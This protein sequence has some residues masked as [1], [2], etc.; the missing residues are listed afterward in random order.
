[1]FANLSSMIRRSSTAEISFGSRPKATFAFPLVFGCLLVFT[2]APGASIAEAAKKLSPLPLDLARP[3]GEDSFDRPP[4]VKA[5]QS[6][7]APGDTVTFGYV[8]ANG[9]AVEGEVWTFD[10]GHSDPFEGWYATD[11]T[12]NTE[13]YFRR[14][15][16]AEWIAD[17]NNMVAPPVLS[18]TGSAW[19]GAFGTEAN[20]LCW[21]SGLGYGN[22]WCQRL[23]SPTF[24][25][26]GSSSVSASWLHF[27]DTEAMYD[28]TTVYLK[29]L[30][31]GD[32]LELARYD[33][34][35][36][37]APD[38]PDSPPVGAGDNVTLDPADF[39]GETSYQIVFE[40]T[41][42]HGWS[43]SDGFA[44]TEYGP[45]AFDNVDIDG[46]VFDFEADLQGWVPEVC[47]G[48][49]SQFGVA[50]VGD[51]LIEDACGC[52]LSGNVLEF[53]DESREHPYGQR[54]EARS[55][56][57]DLLN[58]TEPAG[59]GNLSIL[60]RWAQY[61]ELPQANGVFYRPG[62]DFYPFECV[63]T[64]AEG[65]SGRV[66]QNSFFFV[67]E[68]P[69]C[70]QNVTVATEVDRPVP[71]T[72]EQVRFIFEI[73]ASCDA[74][75]IPGDVCTNQTNFTP[76]IDN[77]VIETTKVPDAPAIS[78][79]NGLRYQDGYSQDPV[80]YWFGPGNADVT[81]NRNF[82]NTTPVVLGDSLYVS[83]PLA[84]PDPESQWEAKLWFQIPRVGPLLN[85][86]YMEWRDRVRDG[87]NIDP[88]LGGD[89]IEWTFAFMDSY[90][91]GTNVA[92]NKYVSYFREDDDDF[93]PGEELKDAN[94]IIADGVLS[95][96]TQVNYFVSS[97]FIG[98]SQQF[99][100]P[101]TTGGFSLEFE[102]LPRWRETENGLKFP[103]TLY[104]DAANDGAQFFVESALDKLGIEVDRYD[105]LD[106]TSN[107]K[108]PFRRG[109][110]A[111]SNN[112][113]TILQLRDY[114]T[115]IVNSGEARTTSIMWPDD[116]LHFADW[117][118]AICSF[119]NRGFIANGSGLASS[120]KTQAPAFLWQLGGDLVSDSYSEYSGDQSDCVRLETEAGSTPA[121]GTSNSLGDYEYDA[122]GNWCPTNHR[123]DVLGLAPGQGGVGN[124]VYLDVDDLETEVPYAQ[125]AN[126][127]EY[128]DGFVTRTVLDGTSYHLLSD[129][130]PLLE[131]VSDS[132]HIV[133]AAANELLAAMEWIWGVGQIPILTDDSPC[134]VSDAPN[135]HGHL[136][137]DVTAMYSSFPN[138]YNRRTTLRFALA[139]S[140]EA[141]VAIYDAAGRL[142]R[143]VVDGLHDA[144]LHQ[145]IWDGTDD[146]G[147][148]LPSGVYW[149]R[150]WDGIQESSAKL[151]SLR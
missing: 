66:G 138:P 58:A 72:A 79:D 29:T 10:H 31:S 110:E 130:D 22:S 40:M 98:N 92:N 95:P 143:T 111:V 24:V 35:I 2:F 103:A 46:T 119:S 117:M 81:R 144:G 100:L 38:H 69:A 105:Y 26:D 139:Q 68:D 48:F 60:S 99:L 93:V 42:D 16:A 76:L 107:W 39:G 17:P 4:A 54:V 141:K 102:I 59:D 124:R 23:V 5:A 122:Y 11:L 101:D 109:L 145:V 77:I 147:R 37:V 8:D 133:T 71:V 67:G 19:C 89:D 96:G 137:S 129:V 106:A 142:V 43:D 90:Q 56:P 136:A 84:G 28:F 12:L 52:K 63:L 146:G 64:G 27:N 73:F 32:R 30:P 62:W 6:R 25:H 3:A 123:F 125:V 115:I 53:H 134:R 20:D 78:F 7:F 83:G 149:A 135:P 94:E 61:S 127:Y 126:E 18:G 140:G 120:M 118:E 50:N 14:I 150:V 86:P 131:C 57:V 75:T 65:W 85:D 74:F 151:V 15:T 80:N 44:T 114:R 108:A 97:N 13:T 113:C 112:G 116:Y 82:G 34:M 1:M 9:F 70:T 121:Y 51:Y 128:L 88:D 148:E 33:G 87:K 55:A 21:E 45:C 36:G 41:S 104:I 49:G 91:V 132:A 47:P